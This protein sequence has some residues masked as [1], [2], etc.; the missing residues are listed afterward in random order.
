MEKNRRLLRVERELRDVIGRYLISGFRGEL[1]GLVSVSRVQVSA[2][3]R[4]A[5]VFV[6]VMGT[7]QEQ[8]QSLESL[9][10]YA[11]DVQAEIHRQLRMKFTP[12]IKFDL[13]RGLEKQLQVEET[14]RRIALEK[15]KK[16]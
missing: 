7:Q 3:L 6:S 15:E 11:A 8:E 16:D 1:T 10:E 14:L 9:R 13:D 4:I 12:R 2:D 5:W